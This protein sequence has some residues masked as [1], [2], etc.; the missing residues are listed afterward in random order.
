MPLPIITTVADFTADLVRRA[1]G[2]AAVRSEGKPQNVPAGQDETLLN[3][4]V[5]LGVFILVAGFLYFRS[6]RKKA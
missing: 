2:G 5:L 4:Q 1:T 6:R 3:K